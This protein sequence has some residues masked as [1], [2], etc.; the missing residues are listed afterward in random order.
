MEFMKLLRVLFDKSP[1]SCCGY[2]P[3]RY[4]EHP[5]KWNPYNQVVQCHNCGA[6]KTPNVEVSGG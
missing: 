6:V 5:I 3:S 2:I 4:G 1:T